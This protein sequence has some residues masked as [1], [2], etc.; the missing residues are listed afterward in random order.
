MQTYLWNEKW[1]LNLLH[2][3]FLRN[4]HQGFW[5]NIHG[6]TITR[7]SCFCVNN[8]HIFGLIS[9]GNTLLGDDYSTHKDFYTCG[10]HTYGWWALKCCIC[11]KL[12][13]HLSWYSYHAEVLKL[14]QSHWRP[15]HQQWQSK[16]ESR[17]CQIRIGTSICQIFRKLSLK[18]L[19][20]SWSKIIYYLGYT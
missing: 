7:M 19:I 5:Q 9:R 2:V 6:V 8:K 10:F 20:F 11:S 18:L 17:L 13:T 4:V 15:A 1:S 12:G 3:K 14:C 16:K